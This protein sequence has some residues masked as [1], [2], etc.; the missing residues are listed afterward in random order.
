M[1]FIL[2]LI[3]AL[4]IVRKLPPRYDMGGSRAS[5]DVSGQ[6]LAYDRFIL[7]WTRFSELDR[8]AFDQPR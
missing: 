6:G 8:E 2:L 5:Y 4:R 7:K 3:A 1:R